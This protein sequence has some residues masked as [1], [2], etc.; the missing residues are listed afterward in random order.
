MLQNNNVLR[1]GSTN[2]LIFSF[3]FKDEINNDAD[4]K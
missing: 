4:V 2:F 1:I 3:T